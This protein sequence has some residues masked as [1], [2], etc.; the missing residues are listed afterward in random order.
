MAKD[1]KAALLEDIRTLLTNYLDVTEVQQISNGLIKILSNYNVSEQ[2]TDLV[3]SDDENERLLKRYSACL[4]LDGKSKKTIYQYIRTCRKLSSTLGK[5][6]KEMTT[7][8]IRYFLA[9][10]MERGTKNISVENQRANISA[11]FTWLTDEE[12]IPKNPV[13]RIKP[14]KYKK[15]LKV[16][17]SDVE[18]DALKN[19]CETEKERALIEVLLSTGVRV[20]ELCAMKI[21]DINVAELSVHVVEGKGNKERTTYTTQVCLK[22]LN[23]YL[24]SRKEDGVYLFYN[25][26]HEQLNPGGV[27]YILKMIAKRGNV[28]NCHPHRFRRTFATN[29][30]KRGMKVQDIQ[31]LL[32]HSNINTT[33]K[34]VNVNDAGV[35]ASYKK[36]ID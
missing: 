20:S 15:E 7:Y 26:D 6:F 17:F 33:M 28:E 23:E 18:I 10:E 25:K 35:K 13:A 1:Y 34:Y 29:L 8:D 4:A 9:L 31:V 16:P 36:Y 21:G 5:H 12:I 11:F 30:A 27:R 24:D 2:C 14:T 19:S 22:Y 3:V 32:G